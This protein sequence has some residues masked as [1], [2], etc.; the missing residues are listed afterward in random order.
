MET[1]GEVNCFWLFIGSITAHCPHY[2]KVLGCSVPPACHGHTKKSVSREC[3][4]SG[5]P[6]FI[7]SGF[8]MCGTQE[9]NSI[10]YIFALC[11]IVLQT[12]ADIYFSVFLWRLQITVL[13]I[14]FSH[15]EKQYEKYTVDQFNNAFIEQ[16]FIVLIF[17]NQ[18]LEAWS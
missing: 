8:T 11:Q 12:L 17:H 3:V 5:F 6:C 4:V 2:M 16:K 13:E 15:C 14:I 1:G 7:S 18:I 10:R 9:L